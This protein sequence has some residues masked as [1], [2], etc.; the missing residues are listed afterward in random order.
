MGVRIFTTCILF[1]ETIKELGENGILLKILWKPCLMKVE[2]FHS[3]CLTQVP[4][5]VGL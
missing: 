4:L 2:E 3:I 5:N 1:H